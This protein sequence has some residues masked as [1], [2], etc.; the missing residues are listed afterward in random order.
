MSDLFVRAV[1]HELSF[2][3]LMK[4]LYK[5]QFNVLIKTLN[6]KM[7]AY[8]DIK[9]TTIPH[10]NKDVDLMCADTIKE[11]INEYEDYYFISLRTENGQLIISF[12]HLYFD[13]ELERGLYEMS[14]QTSDKWQYKYYELTGNV[15]TNKKI[16]TFIEKNIKEVLANMNID[17]ISLSF[18][19]YENWILHEIQVLSNEERFRR[20][21]QSELEKDFGDDKFTGKETAIVPYIIRY[22]ILHSNNI[23]TNNHII[24][25]IEV[26]EI[27]K[28]LGDVTVTENINNYLISKPLPEN[29]TVIHF[30]R[31]DVLIRSIINHTTV[32]FQ[33]ITYYACIP[34]VYE[35]T[36][37]SI[38]IS[39][40]DLYVQV[41][42]L[43][44]TF[45]KNSV[46]ISFIIVKHINPLF[47]NKSTNSSVYNHYEMMI[48]SGIISF[49][50]FSANHQRDEID[51]INEL[52]KTHNK[53]NYKFKMTD[54][55]FHHYELAKSEM[56]L[57]IA[58]KIYKILLGET[59]P[60]IE[61][62]YSLKD[63]E[64]KHIGTI[65]RI[66][67]ETIHKYADIV[68]TNLSEI[69]NGI[70]VKATFI[71]GTKPIGSHIIPSVYSTYE[72]IIK[73]ANN[74]IVLPI[75]G[76]GPENSI[77]NELLLKYK[78]NYKFDKRLNNYYHYVPNEMSIFDQFSEK[79]KKRTEEN[80]NKLSG[81]THYLK[82]N[83]T[84]ELEKA[85]TNNAVI[86]SGLN[87]YVPFMLD[88]FQNMEI[89]EAQKIINEN[90][91]F[92][93]LKYM[94]IKGHSSH[95]IQLTKSP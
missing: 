91:L 46:E 70:C 59:K 47:I 38:I 45:N 25:N 63:E 9:F 22:N 19:I 48:T 4:F 64:R 86:G 87:I 77:I 95:I 11:V 94:S 75:Y 10:S 43:K 92:K 66:I 54:N 1:N 53:T 69:K 15:E 41:W 23:I 5:D 67:M 2:K 84:V 85:L 82:T 78:L 61:F 71:K 39:V 20:F 80:K 83:I 14:D 73:L 3:D 40:L 31:F 32:S 28:Y 55:D 6:P 52:I 17:L 29:F 30:D 27:K 8:R 37:K 62:I 79:V 72:D 49:P 44:I 16:T 21:V 18:R 60:H 24:F 93:D 12:G 58:D 81:L 74:P 90:P 34:E 65:N 42:E 7:R 88:S 35:P 26:E 57:A 68:D 76:T 89:E 56:E 51:I 36:F 13:Q 33:S 50:S